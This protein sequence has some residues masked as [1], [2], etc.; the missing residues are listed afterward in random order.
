MTQAFARTAASRVEKMA[1]SILG[2]TTM[3]DTQ[4]AAYLWK[5]R[6]LQSYANSA[7]QTAPEVGLLD[8]WVITW[9]LDDFMS[10]AVAAAIFNE[11]TALVRETTKTNLTDITAKASQVLS[12]EVFEE[13][14]TLV[15]TYAREHPLTDLDFAEQ[16]LRDEYYRY[17]NIPDSLAVQTVGTLSEVVADL[18]NRVSYGTSA[19]GKNMRWSTELYLAEHGWDSMDLQQRMQV[20][21]GQLENL[22]SAVEVAPDKFQVSLRELQGNLRILFTGLDTTLKGSMVYLD[23]QRLG[24]DSMI[25]RERMAL[26]TIFARERAAIGDELNELT[27]VF[28]DDV[29]KIVR[30]ILIYAII[31]V[32]IVLAFP[33]AA[34]FYLGKVYKRKKS[35]E[36][37][38][39]V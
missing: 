29:G 7:F 35:L 20:I 21:D 18:S 12:P 6:T 38:N 30:S 23:H 14:R 24:V 3:P 33:F 39:S 4:K 34:G 1:D 27:H 19:A 13:Y 31:L 10:T 32:I 26:D 8:T 22:I 11:Q 15:G 5:L 36:E 28:M 2:L 25:Q 9:Q 17:R 16:T 37:R